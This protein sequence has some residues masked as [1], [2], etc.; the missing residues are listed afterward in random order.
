MI[1]KKNHKQRMEDFINE[2]LQNYLTHIQEMYDGQIYELLHSIN[3]FN[4]YLNDNHEKNDGVLDMSKNEFRKLSSKVVSEYINTKIFFQVIDN[5]K[6]VIPTWQEHSLG[7]DAQ[8]EL[9]TILDKI[10][11]P[12]MEHKKKIENNIPSDLDIEDLLADLSDAC[13]NIKGIMRCSNDEK[14]SCSAE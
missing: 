8:K 3:A 9:Y 14:H 11:V 2:E 1:F 4:K 7:N 5:F 6:K 13:I 10:E 12:V